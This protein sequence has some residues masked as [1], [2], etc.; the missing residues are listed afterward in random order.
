MSTGEVPSCVTSSK[1]GNGH[2]PRD[3]FIISL[4]L[5]I[6]VSRSDENLSFYREDL[7]AVGAQRTG[8]LIP[9]PMG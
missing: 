7:D 6:A 8:D 2:S 5:S 9:C 3:A 4:A 1:L